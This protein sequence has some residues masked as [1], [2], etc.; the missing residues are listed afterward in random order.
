MRSQ[1]Q[2]SLNPDICGQEEG[3]AVALRKLNEKPLG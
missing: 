1:M 2:P 3:K